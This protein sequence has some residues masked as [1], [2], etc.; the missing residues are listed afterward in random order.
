MGI[1]SATLIFSPSIILSE[2]VERDTLLLFSFF[3]LFVSNFVVTLGLRAS[4]L[5]RGAMYMGGDACA[6]S[7]L[8]WEK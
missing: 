6:G 8:G 2:G 3:V 4:E 5:W 1:F 7:P